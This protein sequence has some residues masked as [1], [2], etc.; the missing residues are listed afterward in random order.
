MDASQ[1]S[2]DYVLERLS[3]LVMGGAGF[4][5]QLHPKPESLPVRRTIKRA[6][7]LG[8]RA[9][10]TSPYYEP[11]EQLIGAALRHP[12]ITSSYQRSDYVLM[13][14]VGRIREN[15]F[16]YSPDWIRKSVARSLQRFG[17]SYLDVVFCHDIEFVSVEEALQAVKILYQLANSG[18]IRCVGISG[19]SIN[20]LEKVASQARTNYGRAV[21][22]VQVW[23]QLTLQNT[24]LEQGGLDAFRIAGVKAVCNS[25]PLGIGLLRSGGVPVGALGNW[26]PAPPGLRAACQEAA[27]W[28]KGEGDTLASVALRFSMSRAQ[29][30]CR[31]GFRVTT[32]TGVVS[33]SDLEENVRTAKQIL[34]KPIATSSSSG[35]DSSGDLLFHYGGLDQEAVGHDRPL[36]D[37]VQKI[38]GVWLDYDFFGAQKPRVQIQAQ[39]Q[40]DEK[41][42]SSTIELPSSVAS[43]NCWPS[44]KMVSVQR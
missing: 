4:S 18:I 31:P 20:V 14:K 12:E 19:A 44:P 37:G 15:Y 38:L 30:A 24:R 10:D 41:V 23:G 17:T 1:P 26:H 2:P 27:D 6:F 43:A 7:D 42:I 22:V 25:S 28:V 16:D 33:E 29:R 21:D 32:I 35:K 39:A 3:P 40:K 11:S 9:I 5:Y 34:Q 13:T 8:L 36:Y